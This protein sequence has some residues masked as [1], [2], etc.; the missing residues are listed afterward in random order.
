MKALIIDDHPLFRA[1][2]V[3]LMDTIADQCHVVQAGTAE[4]GLKILSNTLPPDE[5]DLILL[6]LNLPEMSGLEAVQAVVNAAKG[7]PVVV[8][9]ANERSSDAVKIMKLGAR[10]YLLKSMPPADLIAALKLV[11]GGGTY[12]VDWLEDKSRLAP[13]EVHDRAIGRTKALTHAADLGITDTDIAGVDPNDALQS[14]KINSVA[15]LRASM[16]ERQFDVLVMLCQ[17]MSNREIGEALLIAEATV[18]VHLGLVFRAM[19]VVNR[20]QATLE[21]QKMGLK[22]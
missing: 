4:A 19:G 21:A 3:H 13:A 16:S 2:L 14:K 12:R 22:V 17:G 11:L 1:A 10:G 9:S 15:R 6:D 20:M 18:K 5:F 7:T 8:V